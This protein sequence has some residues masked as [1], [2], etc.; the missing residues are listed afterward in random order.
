[1]PD[2]EGRIREVPWFADV[3]PVYL[4]ENPINNASVEVVV[5]V[6]DLLNIHANIGRSQC[7]PGS[8]HLSL[9][10]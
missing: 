5:G 10:S 7:R 9:G 6:K 3:I 4:Y 8:S 2:H 1:M